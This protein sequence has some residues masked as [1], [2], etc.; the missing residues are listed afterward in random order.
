MLARYHKIQKNKLQASMF[1]PSVSSQSHVNEALR[2]ASEHS[3]RTG[4]SYETS[5]SDVYKQLREP[6]DDQ[7][8]RQQI[9]E[10]HS[11]DG[12]SAADTSSMVP[13]GK[14]EQFQ[15]IRQLE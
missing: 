10:F 7:I 15:N 9:I 1:M 4:V 14:E 11:E 3:F 2:L 13:K 6:V 12:D 8:L 5:V